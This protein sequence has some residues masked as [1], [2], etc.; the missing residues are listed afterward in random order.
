MAHD[1]ALSLHV[2]DQALTHHYSGSHEVPN[3]VY[4]R[5]LHAA[6]PFARLRCG[7]AFALGTSS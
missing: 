1:V 7:L 4:Q 5:L 3:S 6:S 2:L